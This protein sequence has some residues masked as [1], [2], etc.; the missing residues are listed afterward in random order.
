MSRNHRVVETLR[1]D[2]RFAALHR[3]LEF[4][5]GD[6]EHTAAM[7]A[8]YSRFVARG[9]LVFD[10]GSHV[11][12]RVGS[13]RRLG[14]RVVAVEPHPL[15]VQALGEIY[16]DDDQVRVV[17]AVCGADTGTVPFHLNSANPTVSTASRHFIRSAE[18]APGWRGQVWDRTVRVPSVTLDG[19]IAE[20]G[21][22]A[23]AKIDVEGFEA[24]VL[25][26][27]SRPLPALS[28]EFTTIERAMAYRCLDRL[29]ALGFD[30]FDV[31]LGESMSLTFRRWVSGAAMAAHLAALPDEANAGDV[32]CRSRPDRVGFL[33]R[34]C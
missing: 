1:A 23:F 5:Y 20:Y 12:D 11:G 17:A 10:I 15:C 8:F 22:P 33:P 13:F 9:D 29:T 7:D 28:F 6:P 21:E 26:G 25:A 31:A 18:G 16:A 14:A 30:G 27:L 24:A 34:R 19:L 4:Y 2:P 32:Y 3:S